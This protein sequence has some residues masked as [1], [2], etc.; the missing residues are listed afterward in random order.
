MS[1]EW[2]VA[3]EKDSYFVDEKP[4]GT[5]SLEDPIR[6]RTFKV[7][8]HFAENEGSK[9]RVVVTL[10]K[11]GKA[12]LITEGDCE[13]VIVSDSKNVTRK[14]SDL[15]QY[16]KFSD[17]LELIKATPRKRKSSGFFFFFVSFFCL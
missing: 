7:D 5:R 8:D 3:S 2:L 17:F 6:N 16:L 4:F 9:A 10:I 14:A 15:F 13:Y 12:N 11:L 1:P